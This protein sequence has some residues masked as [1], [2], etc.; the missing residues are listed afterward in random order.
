MSP[1]W[2]GLLH[3]FYAALARSPR[4]VWVVKRLRNQARL[5]VGYHLTSLAGSIEAAQNGEG[6]LA[7]AVAPA[8]R[9]FVDVG[10][11]VGDWTAHLDGLTGG[12][13]E[14]LLIEPSGTALA[15]LEARYGGDA[16]MRIVPAAAADPASPPELTFYEEAAAGQTSTLVAGSSL[17]P[18]TARTVPVVTLDGQLAALGWEGADFVKIDAEGFDLH[19]LRGAAGLIGRQALGVIQF[20]YNT[21]WLAA[22]STLWGALQLLQGAGYA[23]HLLTAK[24][25]V[26]FAYADVEEFYTYANFVAV[27]PDRA[28]LVAPLIRAPLVL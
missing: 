15:A 12:R 7:A 27:A 2:R 11:N 25:L 19:V 5:I 24:G 6:M 20:E 23:V 14:G 28:A 9:R 4:A 17:V 16:R 21:S 13:A 26:P 1:N 10:A 18:T 22:G 8:V 3:R